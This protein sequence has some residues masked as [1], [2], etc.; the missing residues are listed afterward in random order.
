MLRIH[1]VTIF[2]IVPP[3]QIACG[4]MEPHGEVAR[5]SQRANGNSSA[6]RESPIELGFL[7]EKEDVE[8]NENNNRKR[9]ICGTTRNKLLRLYF[10]SAVTT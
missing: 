8:R 1:N 7:H 3:M 10:A 9:Y 4:N 2:Y 5:Y 6:A